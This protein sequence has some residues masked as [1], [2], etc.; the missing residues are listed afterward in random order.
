MSDL[1][2]CQ[3]YA[4]KLA[5]LRHSGNTY[6]Y[7]IYTLT[8]NFTTLNFIVLELSVNSTKYIPS[9]SSILNSNV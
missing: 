1:Y 9:A 6:K 7:L 4:A 5:I 3:F 8:Y 2:K